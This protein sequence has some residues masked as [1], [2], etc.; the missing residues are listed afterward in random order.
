MG[1]LSYRV[2]LRVFG[3]SNAVVWFV[4]LYGLGAFLQVRFAEDGRVRRQTAVTIV[5]LALLLP[6]VLAVQGAIVNL[7]VQ[8]L[9]GRFLPPASRPAEEVR[10]RNPWRAALAVGA[11]FS[12]I[13][14]PVLVGGLTV[15]L[16]Q[17]LG[18]PEVATIMGASGALTIF[19]LI[20][21]IGDREFQRYLRALDGLQASPMSLVTYVVRR[22]ALPWGSANALIN[23]VLA[24]VMYRQSALHPSVVVSLS[25]LRADL[26]VMAFLI[27]VFMALSA[28]P[29]AVTDFRRNLVRL[30][31][32]L[33][34]MPRLWTR[35]GYALGVALM[36]YV[37]VT[38]AAA[39]SDASQVSLG[40]AVLI[41]GLSAGIIAGGAAGMCAVWSL[42][43]CAQQRL[44]AASVDVGAPAT[45][46]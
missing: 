33:P 34:P 22:I 37:V 28:L 46:A 31:A 8:F 30:P 6:T 23:G 19:L 27:T 14:L 43:R 45:A 17:S 5:C 7:R 3:V 1:Q 44:V 16:P 12:V 24:W 9:A 32:T 39:A 2:F 21:Y 15:L 38:G 11:L 41:K 4:I 36:M 35:Y 40:A 29:E 25:E 10:L 13:G 20:V 42:A 18:A 26:A